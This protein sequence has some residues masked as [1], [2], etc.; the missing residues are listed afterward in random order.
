VSAAT[1]AEQTIAD[2]AWRYEALAQLAWALGILDSLPFPTQIC[3]VP[4][5]ARTMYA[6]D[7]NSFVDR[8]ALRPASEILDHLDLVFRLHWA[9]TDARVTNTAPPDGVEAGVV[10]ERHYALNWLTRFD[11]AAWDDVD[12]PT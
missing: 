12:T 5:L 3:D 8:A 4:G 2:H 9:V 1:P 6:L 10:A 11:D 7:A